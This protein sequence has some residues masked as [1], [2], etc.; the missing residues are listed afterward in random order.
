MLL[1]NL[2]LHSK[3]WAITQFHGQLPPSLYLTIWT[4]S[5]PH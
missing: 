2:L 1:C 4:Y 5:N 3:M